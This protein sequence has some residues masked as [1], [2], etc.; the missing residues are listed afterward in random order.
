MNIITCDQGT[1]EWHAA[2]CGRV[3]ASRVADVIAKTKTGYGA[4][5]ANYMA[6]L[7]AERLTGAQAEGYTNAA[8]QWGKDHEA[9]ACDAYAFA[10]EAELETVGFVV[11]PA[12][13]MAGASPDRLVG[14]LGLIEVK[15]PN[16]AT[17]LDTLISRDVPGKYWT[18]IQFQLACTG[19][20][21]CDFVSYD[22][23]LPSR[24]RLFV[25]RVE[26]DGALIAE[27][28]AEVA[29]FIA[30]LDRKLEALDASLGA[31]A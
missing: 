19:R 14:D 10:H 8:M 2:R 5:R 15:C 30:E 7:I 27:L 24:M 12:I 9:D 31:A 4:S 20:D 17:H 25:R 26:R 28:E 11:H 6:E 29:A 13:V 18:Q 16:T 22:P 1:P 23:R 21:W 3:T